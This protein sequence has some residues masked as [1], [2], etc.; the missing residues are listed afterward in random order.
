MAGID[1]NNTSIKSVYN[2]TVYKT[3]KPFIEMNNH[4]YTVNIAVKNLH[5]QYEEAKRKH[6]IKKCETL[7]KTLTSWDQVPQDLRKEYEIEAH[8]MNIDLSSP[9]SDQPT[10]ENSVYEADMSKY[11]NRKREDEKQKE[12]QKKRETVEINQKMNDD[13]EFGS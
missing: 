13:Y 5:E 6:D 2:D 1:I 3:S 4:I 12:K 11:E 7:L 10:L 9:S 8:K